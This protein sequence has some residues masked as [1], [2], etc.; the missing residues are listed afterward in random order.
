M[1][2]VTIMVNNCGVKKD[3]QW[4]PNQNRWHKQPTWENNST[5]MVY[6]DGE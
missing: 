4:I 3:G 2:T 6:T 5:A 1:V